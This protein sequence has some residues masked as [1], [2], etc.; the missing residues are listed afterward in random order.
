M[1][2]NRQEEALAATHTSVLVRV[3]RNYYNYNYYHN[4]NHY[5]THNH[6]HNHNHYTPAR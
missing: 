4:Y 5:H 2:A 3:M 1:K 6:D